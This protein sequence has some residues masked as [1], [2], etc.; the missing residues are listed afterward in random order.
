[1][2]A[3]VRLSHR[4]LHLPGRSPYRPGG[5]L[6]QHLPISGAALLSISPQGSHFN[7][8]QASELRPPS[9][10]P[11]DRSLVVADHQPQPE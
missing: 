9:R 10:E 8:R 1:M 7:L 11:C 4:G 3:A 6:V 5:D 2:G